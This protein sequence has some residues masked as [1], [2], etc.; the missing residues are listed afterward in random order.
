MLAFECFEQR[1]QFPKAYHLFY[2]QFFKAAVGDRKWKIC[3]QENKPFANSNTE[4]FALMILKNNYHAW[5]AQA[6]AEFTFENQYDIERQE[7]RRRREDDDYV[8]SIESTKKSILDEVLPNFEYCTTTGIG[9]DNEESRGDSDDESSGSGV[10]ENNI[11]RNGKQGADHEEDV[12]RNDKDSHAD[13]EHK[14]EE[15]SSWTFV[16]E[17]G[18]W[19]KYHEAQRFSKGCL[20]L[21][22]ENISDTDLEDYKTGVVS[23]QRLETPV[24]ESEKTTPGSRTSTPGSKKTRNNNN[25]VALLLLDE[26]S[27][28]EAVL[29]AVRE[30]RV[31]APR[32]QKKRKILKDLKRFTKKGDLRTVKRRGWS[33]EGY[34]YH[35]ELTKHILKQESADKP[36]VELYRKLAL[37]IE[38]KMEEI[39]QPNKK[40]KLLPDRDEVWQL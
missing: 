17:E 6:Y 20:L 22:R 33:C 4:A 16:T 25:R 14:E 26:E 10:R 39:N 37:K 19:D 30:R 24:V 21:A 29:E 15:R 11:S 9:M 1:W 5:M 2:D 31:T 8:S 12:E 38:S 40:T 23:L 35:A 13:E 7:R 34:N 32:V 36:F 3:L 27:I 28:D 18:D